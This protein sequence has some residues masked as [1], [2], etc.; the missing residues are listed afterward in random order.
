[1]GP[2]VINE[3]EGGPSHIYCGKAPRDKELKQ[4]VLFNAKANQMLCDLKLTATEEAVSW[5]KMPLFNSCEEC[6][7]CQEDTCPKP[8]EEVFVKG[9]GMQLAETLEGWFID[10]GKCTPWKV[11]ECCKGKGYLVQVNCFKKRERVKC[12]RL[13]DRVSQET[14]KTYQEIV[15]YLCALEYAPLETVYCKDA[16]CDTCWDQEDPQVPNG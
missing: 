3:F 5:E 2:R 7:E 13:V 9:S 10:L 16:G 8:I 11:C 1:M 6:D 14:G 4:L 15:D 12:L